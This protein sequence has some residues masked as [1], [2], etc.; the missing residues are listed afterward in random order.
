MSDYLF[1][2]PGEAALRQLASQRSVLA[3]DFDGT[4]APIVDDPA[5]VRLP[6]AVIAA[7]RSL[8]ARVP[9]ALISGRGVADLRAHLPFEPRYVVGNHGAEGLPDDPARAQRWTLVTRGWLSQLS[10]WLDDPAPNGLGLPQERQGL[11]IEDKQLSLTVHYRNA[12]NPRRER[13]RLV[14]MIEQLQPLATVVPG[15]MVINL[16]PGDAPDK[17]SALRRICELEGIASALY[18]GD[19]ETDEQV[20]R[21]PDP[22]WLTIRVEPHP[23]SAARFFLWRQPEITHLL[24]RLV[25]LHPRSGVPR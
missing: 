19:E 21:E 24:H 23:D 3:F 4:L 16:L 12:S 6:R 2:R 5:A 18:A 1:T 20:F 25:S 13:R 9:V 14:E 11:W 15:K 7:M 8:C 22:N 10:G 17:R